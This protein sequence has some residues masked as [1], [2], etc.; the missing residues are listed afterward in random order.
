[1]P[2]TDPTSWPSGVDPAPEFGAEDARLSVLAA[3]RLDAIGDEGDPELSEI[4][5]FAAK[6]CDAPIGLVSLVG[7]KS[8]SFIARAGTDLD[9]TS[10]EVS[11]CAHTMQRGT[12][13]EVPDAERDPR[14]AE[15]P[16][17]T[18]EPHIRFYAGAPLI[19][20]EGAPLGALCVIDSIPRPEGLTDLQREGL[21]VLARAVMR[22]LSALRQQRAAASHIAESARTMREIA[23]L[24]P[25]VIWSADGEGNFDYFNS[26]WT[27]VTGVANPRTA[28]E[29]RPHIHEEDGEKA[30]AS[31]YDSFAKGEPFESEYRLRQADG[32]W[33]W[34]LSRGLPFIDSEG[35]VT[36]W[37]GTLTDVDI[38]RRLSENRD[39]LARELSHRIKNIFAVVAG[40][41]SIRARRHEA[42]R[43]FAEE[44]IGAIRALGR[45]HDFVRPL[46]GVKGDNLR[47]LLMELMAPYA[48]GGDRVTISGD[49]C[50][51]GPRAATPLALVFH[52]LAT[53]SAKYGA[54]SGDGGTVSIEISCD[55]ADGKSLIAW[56]ERGSPSVAEPGTEGFG[57]RLVQMS[58]EGQLGGTIE[59]RFAPDG[60]E[61]DLRIPVESI[62]T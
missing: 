10:R 20:R 37:Y 15:N 2:T 54:L 19:S 39:L 49:D 40:L 14:F 61:V 3:H 51:I 38:A 13:M 23:D 27:E 33:R 47:G 35:K 48:D 21:Q 46:E 58:V 4:A 45:A 17:V 50:P 52:E 62:R 53:N 6:L 5:A 7:A 11:F 41:V 36:R 24:L 44:L 28:E 34:T 29:W 42:A 12:P 56:R 8:Q 59:R 22:R 43:G 55:G 32:S 30:F 18:A 60:L 16:L 25:S 57:T 9:G 26:Q 31:W 1:M